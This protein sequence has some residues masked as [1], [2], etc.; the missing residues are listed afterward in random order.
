MDDTEKVIL[1]M[2]ADYVAG[3][4]NSINRITYPGV[5]LKPNTVDSVIEMFKVKD[6]VACDIAREFCNHIKIPFPNE[7]IQEENGKE[8]SD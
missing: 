7:L 6:T 2:V 4:L 5:D 8:E 1:N 3:A